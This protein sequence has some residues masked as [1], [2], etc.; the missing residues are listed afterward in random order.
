MRYLFNVTNILIIQIANRILA[1]FDLEQWY[2]LKSAIIVQLPDNSPLRY[3]Y[4]LALLN[5]NLFYFLY[6]DLVSEE[7][8]IFP[9][10]KPVQLFKLPIKI[11]DFS[12][13]KERELCERVVNLVN[14]MLTQNADLQALNHKFFKLLNSDLG[15]EKPTKNLEN[16]CELD[17]KEFEK[18]VQKYKV[19][20]TLVQKSEWLDYFEQQKAV[21]LAMRQK[22]DQTDKEI[23]QI[24]YK[25]YGLIDEEIAIVEGRTG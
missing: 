13:S 20:L 14:Q 19:T 21:A 7:T 3:E 11:I 18:E 25:L 9:E 10:V 8:R 2:C 17:W 24:V 23:D 4:L 6:K 5:S 12:E 16:W 22:L 15:I 1:S